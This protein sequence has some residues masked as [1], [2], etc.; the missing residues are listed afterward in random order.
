MFDISKGN[1][2]VFGS[3]RTDAGVH[4]LNTTAHFDLNRINRHTGD[5]VIY[6]FLIF[7]TIHNRLN[8][9]NL[10]YSEKCSIFTLET[11]TY[12]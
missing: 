3:S 10:K 2:R 12:L 1:I 5:P 11:K 9:M 8:L 4:A 6:S 7:P